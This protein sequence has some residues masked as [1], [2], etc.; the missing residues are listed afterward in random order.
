MA[1]LVVYKDACVIYGL[2]YPIRLILT[3]QSVY[4]V[5]NTVQ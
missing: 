4:K 5:L 3:N 1:S 2:Q